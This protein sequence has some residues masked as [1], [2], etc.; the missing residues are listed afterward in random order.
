MFARGCRVL[1]DRCRDR[2]EGGDRRVH[3]NVV[4]QSPVR[5]SIRMYHA[6]EQLWCRKL[7]LHTAMVHFMA[8]VTS[9]RHGIPHME[10]PLNSQ[11]KLAPTRLEQ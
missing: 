7:V 10:H 1:R 8:V 9:L 11:I 2:L 6:D 3:S 5:S 4:V